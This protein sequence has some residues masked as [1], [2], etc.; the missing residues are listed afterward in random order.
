MRLLPSVASDP[1]SDQRGLT[2][3]VAPRT[4]PLQVQAAHSSTV[5]AGFG[6]R[7]APEQRLRWRRTDSALS[8]TRDVGEGGRAWVGLA[9]HLAQPIPGRLLLRV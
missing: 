7:T 6:S 4:P 1:R 5:G 3:A 8:Q 9:A 2:S